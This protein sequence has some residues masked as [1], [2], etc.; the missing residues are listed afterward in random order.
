MSFQLMSRLNKFGPFILLLLFM[1]L[2]AGCSEQVNRK[3]KYGAVGG[4]AAGLGYGLIRGDALESMAAGALAG[5][6]SGAAV[7]YLSEQES[8][9]A[10][11]ATA[12]TAT[13][14]PTTAAAQQ[15]TAQPRSTGNTDI[16]DHET[17]GG[18]TDP[19][20]ERVMQLVDIANTGSASG[21]GIGTT[22]SNDYRIG[23]RDLVEVKVFQAEELNHISRVDSSG[24]IS[25]PLLGRMH[26]ANL[27]VSDAE[28][29]IESGLKESYLQDPHVTVFI[30]EYES[31]RITVEGWVTKPGVYPLKGKTTL[32]QAIA[33]AQGLD[34]LADAEEVVIFRRL[35]GGKIAGYKMDIT[36]IRGGVLKDPVLNPN[37]V[38]VVPQ[39]GSRA[40]LNDVTKTLRGFIGFGTIGL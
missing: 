18:T 12:A 28:K 39:N 34:K 4:G 8:A 3:A 30:Q 33:E 2:L 13:A 21:G 14:A 16:L 5:A 9:R 27:T 24:Y 32:L 20:E 26:I 15:T 29:M 35:E 36:Q 19:R 23:V 25:L 1:A 31:Q 11:T 10:G 38:I 40:L 6:F 22:V 37:D 7:G 17:S